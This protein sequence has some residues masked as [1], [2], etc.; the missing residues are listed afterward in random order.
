MLKPPGSSL[1]YRLLGSG[2]VPRAVEGP[3]GVGGD[4]GSVSP[5]L[6]EGPLHRPPG[7]L[8]S[9]CN[10]P[11][12][13]RRSAPS[14]GTPGGASPGAVQL[15]ARHCAPLSGQGSSSLLPQG[16]RVGGSRE[17]RESSSARVNACAGGGER[18]GVG[19][20]AGPG[21]GTQVEAGPGQL[22]SP[23]SAP[24]KL[25]LS[26]GCKTPRQVSPHHGALLANLSC[27]T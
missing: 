18:T 6:Q 14:P 8:I 21:E 24:S 13:S 12:Q 2:G 25:L 3:T 19:T 20:L 23:P 26:P 7:N 9:A 10:R 27:Q 4:P 15:R 5:S 16:P 11:A 17:P 1:K 22:S